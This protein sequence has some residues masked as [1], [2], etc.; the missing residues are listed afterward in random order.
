MGSRVVKRDES[1]GVGEQTRKRNLA[2]GPM[3]KEK[4]GK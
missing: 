4:E 3:R 2:T 1:R